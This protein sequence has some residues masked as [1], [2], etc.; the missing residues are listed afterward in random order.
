MN[1]IALVNYIEENID[2]SI[3]KNEQLQYRICLTLQS[4]KLKCIEKVVGK[5]QNCP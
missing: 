3:E 1:H 5:C 4:R 2:I